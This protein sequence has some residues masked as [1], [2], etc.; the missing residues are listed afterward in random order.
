VK[1]NRHVRD[2]IDGTE[3]VNLF[4]GKWRAVWE[5][6]GKRVARFGFRVRDE[7]V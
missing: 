5:V 2:V 6:D 4:P 1:T 7:G 3:I